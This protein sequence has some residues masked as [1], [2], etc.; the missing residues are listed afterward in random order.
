MY[1]FR[2]FHIQSK[3]YRLIATPFDTWS[4]E[5]KS[6]SEGRTTIP[7]TIF[8]DIDLAAVT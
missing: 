8:K 3:V 5:L 1:I 6:C 7:S 4:D 2:S